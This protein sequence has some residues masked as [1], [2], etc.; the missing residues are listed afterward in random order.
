[1]FFK[2]RKVLIIGGTGTI[3]KSI[4]EKI[5]PEN[6]KVVRIFSRDE[7]KQYLLQNTFNQP[8]NLRYLI[9]DIRDYDRLFAAM[10][11]IDYIFHAAALKHV[12]ACEYNPFE[13]VLTN[14]IGTNNV[15]KA[16]KARGVKKVIFTS[17]DKAIS[18]TNTYGATKLTAERM[19]IASENNKGSSETTF[20]IVRFG[21]ILASRGS[22]IPL[23]VNQ[24][25]KDRRV[26]VTNGEMS[27]F[28]M[29]VNQATHLTIKAM[30]EARG[31]EIFVLKMPVILLKDLVQVVCQ[32]TCS[33]HGIKLSEI[34]IEE[35]GLRPGEKM[36]EE[37]M[38]TDESVNAY[39]Q[40]DMYVIPSSF[41]KV[42][43]GGI[44]Q[45]ARIGSYSSGDQAPLSLEEVRQLI[46]EE[47]LI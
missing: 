35:I 4:L 36:Y 12:P 21:N 34:K 46:R 25:L 29:T 20:S 8:K 45:R 1:M 23:F 14:I 41:E 22:V 38:T 31:G 43:P 13:A 26:T 9:G 47:K 27:R 5:L 40:A 32:E 19:I 44:N 11:D 28:M 33:I 17:S 39:E 10:E 42:P 2:N 16:A 15:I 30:E 37:L 3:G 7:Y 18:P 6:P 24:I